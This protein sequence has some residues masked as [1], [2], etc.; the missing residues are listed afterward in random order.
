MRAMLIT[1]T[2]IADYVENTR[3]PQRA[4][5]DE[6]I[7]RVRVEYAVLQ[8][9]LT[10][11]ADTQFPQGAPMVLESVAGRE[12]SAPPDTMNSTPLP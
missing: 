3:P 12:Y 1:V 11:T 8:T 9:S 7:A 4:A 2:E 10:G 5:I 6:L